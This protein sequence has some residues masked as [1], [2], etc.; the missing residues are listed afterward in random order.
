MVKIH[1]MRNLIFIAVLAFMSCKKETVL[2]NAISP[3]NDGIND[4]F[5]LP[6]ESP[7]VVIFDRYNTIV[8]SANPYLNNWNANGL[9]DGTY[10]YQINNDISG[11]VTVL[12]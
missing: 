11:Y 1:N 5:V 10:F 8:F 7:K 4:Y 6:F 3:N 2:P 12:R 9:P